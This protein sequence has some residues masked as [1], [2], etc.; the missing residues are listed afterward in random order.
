[1][2]E[3]RRWAV[4][5]V[6]VTVACVNG[7]DQPSHVHDLRVLAVQVE[8]P[9]LMISPDSGCIFTNVNQIDISAL[10]PWLA[11]VTYN[12]LIADPDG[13]GRAIGYELW[14]CSD[15][16]DLTCNDGG[17]RYDLL[18]NVPPPHLTSAGSGVDT[19]LTLPIEPGLATEPDS[20][21]PL[22]VDIFQND[23]YH[24]LGGLLM[25]LIL[26][27][28]TENGEEIYAQKL[29]TFSCKWFPDMTANHN[30]VLRNFY[31]VDG[32]S[33]WDPNMGPHDDQPD[34]G[35]YPGGA[36]PFCPEGAGSYHVWSDPIPNCVDVDG[37]GLDCQESY[38]VPAFDLS[39]V[40]LTESWIIDWYGTLGSFSPDETGGTSLSGATD[41]HTTAWTTASSDPESDVWFW[42]VVRDGR[43]GESWQKRFLHYIP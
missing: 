20:G 37:G 25:P 2:R 43:G 22:L 10:N 8:P 29:I 18:Q 40:H 5:L 1:M 7:I 6:G 3:D 23:P 19:V 36:Q 31:F 35:C 38:S 4:L 41:P 13:G 27:L 17:I 28:K 24:G 9:E 39:E 12:A 21:T 16:N 42:F 33:P 26:H 11:S 15:P 30:P 34:G 14:A 32:G